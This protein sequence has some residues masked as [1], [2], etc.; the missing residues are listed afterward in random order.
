ME[1]EIKQYNQLRRVFLCFPELVYTCVNHGAFYIPPLFR[2]SAQA[3]P[4]H[5]SPTR[6]K[7][8]PNPRTALQSTFAASIRVP[9]TM[10]VACVYVHHLMRQVCQP[11]LL[12]RAAC[13]RL[14]SGMAANRRGWAVPRSPP[15]GLLTFTRRCRLGCSLGS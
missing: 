12:F 5:Q 14:A 11:A 7:H 6:T 13:T 9:C 10:A 8:A 15:E 2:S 4:S 1:A 3:L